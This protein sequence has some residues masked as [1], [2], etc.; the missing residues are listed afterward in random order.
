MQGWFTPD[1]T[2]HS[3]LSPLMNVGTREDGLRVEKI[4]RHGVGHPIGTTRPATEQ[5]HKWIWV[6]GCDGCCLHPE[7]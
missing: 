1:G 7:F 2:W 5:E 6:H 3:Q 4:C